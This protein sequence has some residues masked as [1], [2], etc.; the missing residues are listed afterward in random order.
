MTDGERVRRQ[1]WLARGV[2]T[3]VVLSVD[4]DFQEWREREGPG[5][6]SLLL[7]AIAALNVL[8]DTERAG[9]WAS[10]EGQT[11]MREQLARMEALVNAY[12]IDGDVRRIARTVVEAIFPMAEKWFRGSPGA[13]DEDSDTK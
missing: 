6:E 12:G 2:S 1:K 3:F 11:R 7:D 10:V 5:A 13:N 8:C 4:E 9:P